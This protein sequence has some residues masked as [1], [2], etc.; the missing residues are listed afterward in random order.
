VV[1]HRRAP[2]G[3]TL[4]VTLAPTRLGWS[5]RAPASARPPVCRRSGCA[6]PAGTGGLCEGHHAGQVAARAAVEG[7]PGAASSTVVVPAWLA[8]VAAAREAPWR[9]R[10]TCRG[11]TTTMYPD[12]DRGHPA[13]YG[14]ALA[15][16]ERCPVVDECSSAGAHEV[17]G[18]W[19]ETTPADRRRARRVA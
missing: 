4:G 1:R 18:V 13:V 5:G 17:H 12:A 3:H 16:C 7:R 2:P 15:L 8:E 14:A 9:T 19:G 11:M 6:A 10:A